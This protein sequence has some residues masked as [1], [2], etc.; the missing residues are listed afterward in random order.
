MSLR[1]FVRTTNVAASWSLL[2]HII[3]SQISLAKKL[4]N[5]PSMPKEL[6][7]KTAYVNSKVSSSL[8]MKFGS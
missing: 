5:C 1:K 4:I 2:G 6:G 3:T 7:W 8:K